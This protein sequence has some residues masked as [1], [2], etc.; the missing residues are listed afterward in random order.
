MLDK[1]LDALIGTEVP[2]Q[3][4]ALICK[5]CF[6]HNGL[7]G[8]AGEYYGASKFRT[9]LNPKIY[10]NYLEMTAASKH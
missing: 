6:V 5:T 9:D 8:N 7:V 1:L 4:Y 2:N 10:L 3:Q